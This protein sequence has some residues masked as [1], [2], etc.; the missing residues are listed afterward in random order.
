MTHP[1]AKITN[2]LK[3]VIDPFVCDLYTQLNG[4]DMVFDG[5]IHSSFVIKLHNEFSS[6]EDRIAK[7]LLDSTDDT[8]I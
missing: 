7:Q 5:I 8:S 4:R 6:M 1:F 2:R 3:T